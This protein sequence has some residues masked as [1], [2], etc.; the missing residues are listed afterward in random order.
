MRAHAAIIAPDILCGRGLNRFAW[1]AGTFKVLAEPH[2]KCFISHA[3]RDAQYLV[4]FMESAKNIKGMQGETVV[5]KIGSLGES[6]FGNAY[7]AG[8]LKDV[9]FLRRLELHP[10]L[11]HGGGKEVTEVMKSRGMRPEFYRGSRITDEAALQVLM[12]VMLRIGGDVVDCIGEDAMQIAGYRGLLR[13]APADPIYG[14]VGNV[15]E[16]DAGL[17]HSIIGNGKTPV[18]TPLGFNDTQVYNVNGDMAASAV[19]VALKSSRLVFVTGIDGVMEEQN[20]LREINGNKFGEMLRS[21][22]INGGMEP[23]VSAGILAAN[24]GVRKVSI[25]NGTREHALLSELMSEE[26][27]GTNVVAKLHS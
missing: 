21:N 5:I 9:Q 2:Q 7:V 16:V 23:K 17:L 4:V 19:A 11:V 27:T 8:V 1:A 15:I 14:Y 20:L 3:Q 10:V 12:E 25:I 6:S 22:R 13:V 26:G 24:N 18:I